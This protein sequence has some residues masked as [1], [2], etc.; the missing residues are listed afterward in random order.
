MMPSLLLPYLL[1]AAQGGGLDEVWFADQQVQGWGVGDLDGDGLPD[2]GLLRPSAQVLDLY[3][4]TDGLPLGSI[5]GAPLA[6]DFFVVEP[7]GDVDG[8]GFGDLALSDIGGDGKVVV[9]SWG[10]ST[11]LHTLLPSFSNGEFGRSLEAVGDLDGD[12]VTDLLVGAPA[13]FNDDGRVYAYSGASGA[14]LF[15]SSIPDPAAAFGWRIVDLGDQDGDGVSDFAASAPSADSLFGNDYGRIYVFSGATRNVI[16]AL[17]GA[18]PDGFLGEALARIDDLDGDGRADLLASS[19]D[20]LSGYSLVEAF[21]SN[22]WSRLWSS[23]PFFAGPPSLLGLG[24][25]SGD[26][27][28]D[29]VAGSYGNLVNS[30]YGG[31]AVLSGADGSFVDTFFPR[32]G[33][34]FFGERLSLVGDVV[35]DEDPEFLVDSLQGTTLMGHSDFLFP[36]SAGLSQGQGGV[37]GMELDFPYTAAG[38]DYQVLFSLAGPGSFSYLGLA[39]PLAM[40][41]LVVRS[42]FGDY[43]FLPFASGMT[44]T[45]DADARAVAGFG[46][47]PGALPPAAVGRTCAVAAIAGP[48][49]LPPE[50]SS[51]AVVFTVLP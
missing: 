7:L 17:G 51:A 30:T 43:H 12:G 4:G 49:G 22:G 32:P 14:Q 18:G 1:L 6:M 8:D 44:G 41:G 29:L 28:S 37:V 13:T 19:R 47:L 40:D 42:L 35:R 39:V 21:G 48:P 24:D 45:L 5:D 33:F 46:A 38:Y 10:S 11:V 20:P 15:Q 2:Y 34:D 16:V 23:S 25:W 3:S 31:I 50:T 26:G 9:Y 36:D 27:R